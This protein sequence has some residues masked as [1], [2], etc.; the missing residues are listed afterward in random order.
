M[1]AVGS[2]P[3]LR[4]RLEHHTDGRVRVRVARE[5]RSV[6]HMDAVRR[7]LSSNPAVRHVD[8]NPRTGSVLLQGED[9]RA[10]VE[11]LSE[12]LDVVAEAG[13]PEAPTA[14]VESLVL[15][16]KKTDRRLKRATGQRFSL[17]WLV[18]AAFI[19]AGVRQLMRQGFTLGTIPWYVLLYYGVDAF[20]KLHPEHAPRA[21]ASP[22]DPAD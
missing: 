2:E 1:A 11:A 3:R 20:L 15:L 5:G 4:A 8:V 6:E 12:V 10:L 13:G 16:V 17:R 21:R 7:K 18:P 9:V 19:A 22:A 14:G